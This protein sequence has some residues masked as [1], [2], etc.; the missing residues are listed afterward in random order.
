MKLEKKSSRRLAT[1]RVVKVDRLGSFVVD[2]DAL[3][4]SGVMSGQFEA[5]RS[6]HRKLGKLDLKPA[7]R[8][9]AKKAI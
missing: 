8:R 3:I 9:V 7:D 5:A 4:K 6:L 1:E 2:L